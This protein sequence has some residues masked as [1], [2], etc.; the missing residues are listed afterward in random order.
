LSEQKDV[1][2]CCSFCFFLLPTE[3]GFLQAQ[4]IGTKKKEK[5]RKKK[6]KKEK[7]RRKKEREEMTQV[8]KKLWQ[9]QTMF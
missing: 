9:L 7:K 8:R 3:N 2:C 6:K 5:K 4:N 1:Y